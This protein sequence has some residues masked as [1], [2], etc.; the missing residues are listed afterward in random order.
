MT[1][2]EHEKKVSNETWDEKLLM[3]SCHVTLCN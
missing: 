1:S 3:K 2:H